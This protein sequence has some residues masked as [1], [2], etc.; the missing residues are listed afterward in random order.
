MVNGPSHIGG[1]S[2]QQFEHGKNHKAPYFRSLDSILRLSTKNP[3]KIR[4]TLAFTYFNESD[5]FY[6]QHFTV[7]LLCLF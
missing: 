2:Q 4:L 7:F 3:I 6:Q 1:D 5:I